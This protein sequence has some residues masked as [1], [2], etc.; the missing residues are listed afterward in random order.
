MYIS[1]RAL[2]PR[3]QPSPRNGYSNL[4][5]FLNVSVISCHGMTNGCKRD[6][7]HDPVDAKWHD[8]SYV[9]RKIVGMATVHAKRRIKTAHL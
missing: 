6:N 4:N 8:K 3:T 7:K 5:G 9:K 1:G 2:V